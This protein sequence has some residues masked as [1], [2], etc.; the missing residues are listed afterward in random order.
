[1]SVAIGVDPHGIESPD[2]VLANLRY[3]RIIIMTDADVDGAHI[4]TLLLTHF[5][6]HL[7]KLIEKGHVFVAQPPLYRIDVAS[8][9]KGKPAR[10]FYA[11]DEAERASILARLKKEGIADTKIELGRFKGLGEMNPDQLKE[12]SMDPATRRVTPVYYDPVMLTEINQMFELL[13][14]ESQ[15]AGR[16]DWM[17]EKGSTVEADV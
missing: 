4:Q 8:S 10:R 6:K 11:L 1:M 9:G 13:M 7:P 3:R 12:T 14:G 17:T 16:R 5:Y 15:A 2:S